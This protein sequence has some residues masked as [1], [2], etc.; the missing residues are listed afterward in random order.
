MTAERISGNTTE[1]AGSVVRSSTSRLRRYAAAFSAAVALGGPLLAEPGVNAEPKPSVVVTTAPAQ[2]AD[3]IPWSQPRQLSLT[4]HNP[5]GKNKGYLYVGGDQFATNYGASVVLSQEQPYVS[6]KD[7]HSLMELA[8]ESAD[9][10]QIV[11]VGWTV[12]PNQFRDS[13]PHLFTYHWVDG[14]GTCYDACGFE[15]ISPDIKPGDPVTPG[16]SGNYSIQQA[17]NAWEIRYDG[18]LVGDYPDYLWGNRYRYAGLVQA[19][20]EVAIGETAP[21]TDMG[22]GTYGDTFTSSHAYIED[23]DI[24]TPKGLPDLTPYESNGAYYSYADTTPTSM[25]L[26]G[27]G[28][29]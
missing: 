1:Q 27:P 2:S 19:F 9:N 6:P 5:A 16:T 4:K 8:V 14:Q 3:I 13:K 18:E 24:N 12:D 25:L 20:G 17:N 11:E 28:A 21:C 29:C 22:A 10:K 15:Q 26:G 7:S 23:F